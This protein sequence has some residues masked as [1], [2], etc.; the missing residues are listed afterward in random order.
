MSLLTPLIGIVVVTDL[1]Q[2]GV[3]RGRLS[4]LPS[5]WTA[6]RWAELLAVFG[7]FIA[8]M[9][10]VLVSTPAPDPWR[11]AGLLVV[12]CLLAQVIAAL[13]GTGLGLLVPSRVL[14]FVMTLL[15]APL[16]LAFG[17]MG[18]L[19]AVRD[20]VLPY[21]AVR[22]LF[23]GTMTATYGG[24]LLVVLVLWGL[25]LNLLGASRFARS[26]GAA[27]VGPVDS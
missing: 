4:V 26:A 3:A 8:A 2:S 7:V 16:W 9:A 22:H 11:A 24:Q 27:A 12:G 1:R 17:V 19:R 15:P 21:G 13:T 14:A 23:E 20:C 5:I 25:G 10:L 18:P 6:L